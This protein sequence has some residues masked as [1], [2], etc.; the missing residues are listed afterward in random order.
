MRINSYFVA[1]LSC[2]LLWGA[3]RTPVPPPCNPALDAS[4]CVMTPSCVGNLRDCKNG[5]LDGCETDINNDVDNCGGCGLRCTRPTSGQ[6]V[7]EDGLCGV[8]VCGE[9]YQDCNGDPADGCETDTFRSTSDCGT[10]G[11]QC[12]GGDHA[13]ASCGFG[14]CKLACQAGYLD[15]NG[16]PADGCEVNGA[17]DRNNC[18]TCGTQCLSS[19]AVNAVCSAGSCSVSGCAAPAL[20]CQG[21]AVDACETDSS[22]DVNNCGACGIL[23]EAVANGTPVCQNSNCGIGSCS[24]GYGDCNGLLADGCEAGLTGDL[25]NCGS[26]GRACAASETCAAGTCIDAG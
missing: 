8:V 3:C 7:C 22:T 14:R 6:A 2:T 12:P 9:R 19:G 17:S 15:C 4:A 24:S 23:C 26:C 16:D 1:F 25:N 18:G 5:G 13:A 10:C 20:S 11:Q 21:G